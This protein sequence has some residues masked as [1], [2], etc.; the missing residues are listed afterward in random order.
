MQAV[1]QANVLGDIV[2]YYQNGEAV[3]LSY[4]VDETAL[5]GEVDDETGDYDA[6]DGYT[7]EAVGTVVPIRY[8]IAFDGTAD[9]QIDSRATLTAW[10]LHLISPSPG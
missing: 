10:R 4:D 8:E 6:D 2:S 7:T 3:E 9:E 5:L 1:L